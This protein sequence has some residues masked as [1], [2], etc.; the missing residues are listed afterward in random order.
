LHRDLS[1]APYVL[2]L[3]AVFGTLW[4]ERTSPQGTSLRIQA[5]VAFGVAA[6]TV[7]LYRQ[8][9][10]G[11]YH[12][13]WIDY[14]S[15]AEELRHLAFLWPVGRPLRT[16]HIAG[17]SASEASQFAWVGWYARAV[18]R[19]GGLYPGVLTPERL[20]TWRSI[21]TERFMEPQ[22][23]YHDRTSSRFHRVQERL[24]LG[25]FILFCVALVLS[26]VDLAFVMLDRPPLTRSDLFAAS[27]WIAAAVAV[28]AL[29]PSIASA[30]HAFLSQGDFWNLSRRSARMCHQLTKLIATVASTP[31]S[32]EEL[33]NVAEDASD[34][35]RDEVLNWRVFVR[36]KPPALG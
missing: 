22:C 33:G 5:W 11:R 23:A 34:V 3:L 12:D 2:A 36:L 7:A 25:A 10:R 4:A 8:A 9:V 21:L 19:Q 32:I 26:M 29:F 31:P 18:A 28:A 27:G 14:R 20:E 15:L 1:T 17:E 24:H 35:M 30:L 13:R 16:P 6:L